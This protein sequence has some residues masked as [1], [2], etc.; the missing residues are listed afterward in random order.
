MKRNEQSRT[1]K[2]GGSQNRGQFLLVMMAFATGYMSSTIINMNQLET[3]LNQLTN[4]WWV[5]KKPANTSKF[6]QSTQV[7]KQ[8]RTPKLEFYTVLTQEDKP[9]LPEEK[10]LAQQTNSKAIAEKK[11]DPLEEKVQQLEQKLVPQVAQKDLKDM[12]KTPTEVLNPKGSYVVQLASFRYSSQAQNFRD[13]LIVK[14][15]NVRIS[16]IRQGPMQ[17]YR[18]MLGPYSSLAEAQK[19]KLIFQAKEHASGMIRQMDA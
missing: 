6:N 3:W 5:G 17:W 8:D 4:T 7:A 12:P 10:L 13:K 1:G 18:V 16:A 19:A 11:A 9:L 14:G 15:F 2:Q